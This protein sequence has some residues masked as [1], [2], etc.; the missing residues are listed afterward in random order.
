MGLNWGL[1]HQWRQRRVYSSDLFWFFLS[2]K[3]RRNG[4]SLCTSQSPSLSFFH[5]LWEGGSSEGDNPNQGQ[6][7]DGRSKWK[8]HIQTALGGKQISNCGFSQENIRQ[9]M[10]VLWEIS[11]KPPLSEDLSESWWIPEGS[12]M[13]GRLS[14]EETGEGRWGGPR[15]VVGEGGWLLSTSNHS[16]IRVSL[17]SL[18]GQWETMTFYC[19][20]NPRMCFCTVLSFF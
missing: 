19:D 8:C 16:S 7:E 14:Q 13:S 15:C 4:A 11:H 3:C 9:Q 18:H 12:R 20:H 5:L 1:L 6:G 2:C 10:A 17:T